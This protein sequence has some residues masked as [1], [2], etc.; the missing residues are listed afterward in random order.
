MA[1]LADRAGEY[2]EQLETD[3]NARRMNARQPARASATHC[4]EC[5]D[6]IPEKRR[7]AAQGCTMCAPCQ[8]DHEQRNSHL[9]R[10]AYG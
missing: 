10:R 9:S 4:E 8:S 2:L 1:D 6:P 3:R 5:G 7:A